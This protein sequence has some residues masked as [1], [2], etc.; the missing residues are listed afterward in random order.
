MRP[1][2]SDSIERAPDGSLRAGRRAP[3]AW[4][5]TGLLL[6]GL[7]AIQSPA[8]NAS[9]LASVPVLGSPRSGARLA[10]VAPHFDWTPSSDDP[11]GCVEYHLLVTIP[12]WGLVAISRTLR[13]PSF[14]PDATDALLGTPG[15]TLAYDW[16][17]RA[18]HCGGDWSAWSDESR[19]TVSTPD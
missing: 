10:Q 13:E 19:F 15:R 1:D 8:V 12:R 18:R 4:R 14:V 2:G 11:Q 9:E 3:K 5:S 17:V 6:A 7:F 16:K